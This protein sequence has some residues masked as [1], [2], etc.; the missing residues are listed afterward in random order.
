M[1]QVIKNWLD[2]TPASDQTIVLQESSTFEMEVQ[3]A[4]MWYRGDANEL[5]QFFR[6]LCKYGVRSGFW[7]SVP[8]GERIRKIHSGL[9]AIIVDTIA[10]IVKSDMDKV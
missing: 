1:K 9:P 8:V 2:I 6:Q 4:K 3:R 10:Y 7:E 5:L